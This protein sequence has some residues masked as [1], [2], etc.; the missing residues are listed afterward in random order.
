[1]QLVLK[2]SFEKVPGHDAYENFIN[3]IYTFYGGMNHKRYLSFREFEKSRN[4]KHIRFLKLFPVRWADSHREATNRIIKMYDTLHLHLDKIIADPKSAKPVKN[5][6]RAKAMKLLS[7]LTDENF[8]P[9]LHFH[10]DVL[11]LMSEQSLYY[12]RVSATVIG[13]Y[14]R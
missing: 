2:H 6:P 3:S 7:T 12:Q 11:S 10:A 14:R 1:M 9:L 5:P 4:E 8:L 13:E